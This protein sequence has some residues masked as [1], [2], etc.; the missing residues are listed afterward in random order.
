M[1]VKRMEFRELIDNEPIQGRVKNSQKPRWLVEIAL[2]F[3]DL[4]DEEKQEENSL[5]APNKSA[6]KHEK[7]QDGVQRGHKP[8]PTVLHLGGMKGMAVGFANL[9]LN[10]DH[11]QIQS[12]RSDLENCSD[13]S[14]R[15]SNWVAYKAVDKTAGS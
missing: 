7:L 15:Y 13:R 10:A 1:T 3:L 11:S 8:H 2:T 14:D 5:P 4:P 12:E 9:P 6:T